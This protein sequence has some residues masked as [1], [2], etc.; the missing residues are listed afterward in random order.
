MFDKSRFDICMKVAKIL[1]VVKKYACYQKQNLYPKPT[2][3]PNNEYPMPTKTQ[4][5][6]SFFL[7]FFLVPT[8]NHISSN[9]AIQTNPEKTLLSNQQNN[10]RESIPAHYPFTDT[11]GFSRGPA[12]SSNRVKEIFFKTTV[13]LTTQAH[14]SIS[15]RPNHGLI[16]SSINYKLTST[17][18]IPP[19]P[20]PLYPHPLST[21]INQFS[22]FQGSYSK[23]PT[24]LPPPQ[25]HPSL[26]PTSA[27]PRL[28][29]L[30]AQGYVNSRSVYSSRDGLRHSRTKKPF[31]ILVG[32]PDPR[33][34]LGA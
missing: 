19:L 6:S 29:L 4:I 24:H 27:H 14:S 23:Q 7:P 21:K 34:A 25:F 2:T 22:G 11:V 1:K 3:K 15:N 28:Q 17:H 33:K 31:P 10:I 20:N 12:E 16:T 30:G 5:P 18:P 26:S 32:V 8:K 9:K 13:A